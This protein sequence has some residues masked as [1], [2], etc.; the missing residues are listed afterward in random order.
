MKW[1]RIPGGTFF[2]GENPDDKFA[3]DTERPRHEVAV[4]SF[5]LS[6]APVTVGEFREFLPNH[7]TGIPADWPCS[8]VS[9]DD[10]VQYCLWRGK[11]RLPTEKEWE[12]AAR[13]GSQSPYPWGDS[14]NSSMANYLYSE[15]GRRIGCGHRTPFG[16]FPPNSFGLYDM[17]GNVCE[18]VA[19]LWR[20]SYTSLPDPDRRVL[21]GGA[22]D[23]LPRLLRVSW[24]DSLHHSSR[25]DNVGFRL[26]R[27]LE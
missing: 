18:W 10:A 11:C 5:E 25:R 23:Y 26:A 15:Q 19:D 4:A 16:H 2:M 14:I 1:I 12:Y 20:P 24:R 7:E 8:M 13:A 21:R 27:D 22:W 6:E 3:N 17:V 9:W